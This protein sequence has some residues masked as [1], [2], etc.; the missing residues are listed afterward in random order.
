MS[1]TVTLQNETFQNLL[2]E[3]NIPDYEPT[4]NVRALV[5]AESRFIKDLKIN[6]GNVLNNNQYLN[7]K[8]SLL[9]ALGV[10]VIL[11]DGLRIESGLSNRLFD[12]SR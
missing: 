6:V 11:F 1:A 10:L 8:E 2:L 9:L 7:R 12:A 3:L 4:A 5:A